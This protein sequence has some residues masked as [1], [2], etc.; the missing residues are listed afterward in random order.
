MRKELNMSVR[1]LA[2]LLFRE[3]EK[4]NSIFTSSSDLA[5][6]RKK[7]FDHLSDLERNYFGA[8]H[9]LSDKKHIMEEKNARRCIRVFKNII[10]P[11]NEKLSGFS[12]LDR[13]FKIHGGD[14]K[15]IA[16]TAQGFVMEF[17]FMVRG[18]NG[19]F[20][21]S[22]TPVLSAEEITAESRGRVLDDYSEQMLDGF[23]RFRKGTDPKSVDNQ[24]VIKQKINSR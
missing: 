7:L 18:I 6:L 23:A 1:E 16:E 4:I 21:L 19:N 8:S 10:S 20:H 22:N 13:L 12:A 2:G 14:E 24:K 17:L 9:R 3:D 15:V 11:E 5:E